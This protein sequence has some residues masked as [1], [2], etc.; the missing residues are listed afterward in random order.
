MPNIDTSSQ[1]RAIQSSDQLRE[2][3]RIAVIDIFQQDSD[4][5]SLYLFQK[6]RPK[7]DILLKPQ[8]VIFAVP[9]CCVIKRVDHQF[10][11]TDLLGGFDPMEIPQFGNLL[12][13]LS[14]L[15]GPGS[16]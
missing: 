13:N 11:G 12:T 10:V 16:I 5:T 2:G 6:L 14:I 3:I 7:L 15:M 8:T 4:P 1:I 9:C